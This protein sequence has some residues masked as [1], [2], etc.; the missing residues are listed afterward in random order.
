MNLMLKIENSGNT[1]ADYIGI[2]QL[3]WVTIGLILIKNHF[4][5]KH[6]HAKMFIIWSLLH[7][8]P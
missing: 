2:V 6:E 7:K 5:Q 3:K 1:F 4:N 8:V